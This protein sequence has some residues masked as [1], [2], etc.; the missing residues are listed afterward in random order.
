[1]WNLGGFL[2]WIEDAPAAG[3]VWLARY[4]ALSS[5]NDMTMAMLPRYAQPWNRVIANAMNI[6]T[7]LAFAGGL[8]AIGSFILGVRAMARYGTVGE[9]CDGTCWT[10][11]GVFTGFVFLTILAAPLS[12]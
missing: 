7:F 1:M 5:P 4:A 10:W 2:G 9:R 12:R 8:G 3:A 11:R 6:F